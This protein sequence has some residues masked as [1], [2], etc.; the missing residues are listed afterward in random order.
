M[1]N[2][3]C[4]QLPH[5][6]PILELIPKTQNE[7]TS[8]GAA[9]QKSAEDLDYNEIMVVEDFDQLPKESQGSQKLELPAQETSKTTANSESE[10]VVVDDLQKE[11]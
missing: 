9:E 4:Q 2:P 7:S 3:S 8:L 6:G 11:P 1:E 10:W 5:S